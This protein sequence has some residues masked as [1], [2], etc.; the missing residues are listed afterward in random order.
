MRHD[1]RWRAYAAM[2]AKPYGSDDDDTASR[3]GCEA[4]RRDA[5]ERRPQP[6]LAQESG[7]Y[8]TVRAMY[9]LLVSYYGG[10]NI[11]RIPMIL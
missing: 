6:G 4:I 7:S 9:E 10:I 1:L 11:L 3:R 5:V 8:V 2:Q